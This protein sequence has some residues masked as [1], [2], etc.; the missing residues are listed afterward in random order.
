MLL[1]GAYMRNDIADYPDF[2]N[3]IRN[4]RLVFLFGTGISSALSCGK[5]YNWWKWIYQ[6]TLKIKDETVASALAESI[7]NDKSTNNMIRIVGE[8]IKH[9]KA[10][11]TYD[12]WMQEKIEAP[13][14]ENHELSTVL[15]KLLIAQDIFAT[16]NYDRLLESATG[17][18]ALSYEEPGIAYEMIDKQKSSAVLHLHGIYDSKRGIDNIVADKEQYDAVIGNEGAQFIQNILGT[19]T[20]VFIGCGQTTEDGNISRFIEFSEKHHHIKQTYFLLHDGSSMPKN[21]PNFIQP[22]LYGDTFNELPAFLNDIAEERLRF[23]IE[24][25]PIIDRSIYTNKTDAFGLSE[26]HFSQEKLNFC[27]RTVELAR[28]NSFL[29]TDSQFKWW[30]ITG[31]G[32]AGKSRLALE[33]LKRSKIDWY[34]FFLNHTADKADVDRFV[35]FNDTIIVIDYVKGNEK[36]IAGLVSL[37]IDKYRSVSFKLRILFLERDN[38][39][40]SGSWFSTLSDSFDF[41]HRAAFNN[42]EYNRNMISKEHRFY[43]LTIWT[44]VLF[45]N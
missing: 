33:L 31:Q 15:K 14:L 38:L 28:L 23:K 11:G 2:L 24:N 8:V 21:L 7:E 5:S 17:L 39:L 29:E 9:T 30:A 34:G 41:S 4:N 43:I 42:A 45:W 3:A 25:N 37:M 35:P 44:T 16:T 13:A 20:V 22:I 32:G 36:Q 26:Y 10:A 27:G 19:R 6:G 40:L 12:S 18:Q 1:R